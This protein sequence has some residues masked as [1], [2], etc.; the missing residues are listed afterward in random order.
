MT[1]FLAPSYVHADD[2]AIKTQ[3]PGENIYARRLT[4]ALFRAPKL[5]PS[6]CFSRRFQSPACGEPVTSFHRS[7]VS[8]PY[9]FRR[10]GLPFFPPAC[11]C[12]NSNRRPCFLLFDARHEP[13]LRNEAYTCDATLPSVVVQTHGSTGRYACTCTRA[14]THEYTHTRTH[15]RP[16]TFAHTSDPRREC[17]NLS[18]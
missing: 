13:P 2:L 1:R 14:H 6:R 5:F 18:V 8:F 17:S 11:T 12:L 7:R 9:P 3:R 15:S 10:R 4:T 16:R